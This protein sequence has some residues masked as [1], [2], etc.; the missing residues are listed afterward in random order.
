[1]GPLSWLWKGLEDV[2]NESSGAVEIPVDVFATLIEQTALLLGQPSL[3][4]SYK[5]RLNILKTL[6]KD[7]R[8]T[9]T[10]LKE[11]A[12]LMQESESHLFG[13][14]IRF[15]KIEIERSKKQS[16]EVFKG[17]NERN[18]PFRKDPLPHQNR[19]QAV[20]QYYYAA[21]TNNR[22]Q[23]KEVSVNSSSELVP[24]I[25]I[26]NSR[27]C[28]SNSKKIICKKYSKCTIKRKTTLLHNNLE[29]K[30]LRIKKYLL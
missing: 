19:S 26:V 4:I 11:K 7:P 29:K 27:A 30:V 14:N 6:L 12:A 18:T 24:L 15:H 2:R 9:K 22:D 8:K 16:L 28:S 1:M 13:K 17:S 10:L 25:K 20:G 21:K 5:R 3:S 23:N